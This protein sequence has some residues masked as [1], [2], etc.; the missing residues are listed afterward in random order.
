MSRDVDAVDDEAGRRVAQ[1][2]LVDKVAE[3]VALSWS[4]LSARR[5]S[6]RSWEDVAAAGVKRMVV[7]AR[8]P[9]VQCCSDR[10]LLLC[11]PPRGVAKGVAKHGR[12][13][14]AIKQPVGGRQV[15]KLY[16]ITPLRDAGRR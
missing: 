13:A 6:R 16:S 9:A 4:A 2:Q 11:C 5:R 10:L 7:G 8:S 15:L 14:V 1:M 3:R 12:D